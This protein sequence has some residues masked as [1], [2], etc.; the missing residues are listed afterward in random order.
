MY[1]VNSLL[2]N[3]I[4][5]GEIISFQQIEP[6]II[7]MYIPKLELDCLIN[8]DFKT[9]QMIDHE[10]NIQIYHLSAETCEYIQLKY[11]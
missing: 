9:L 3:Y 6:Q 1:T 8:F 4:T 10:H 2:I 11:L 7:C 5:N